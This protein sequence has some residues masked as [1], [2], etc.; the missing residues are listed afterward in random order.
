M[1]F[2]KKFCCNWASHAGPN[3]GPAYITWPCKPA[4]LA[5]NLHKNLYTAYILNKR[6]H[7]LLLFISGHILLATLG[8]ACLGLTI[9]V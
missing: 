6:L 1:K 8:H 9:V 4:A 7:Y 5:K 3:D 2:L